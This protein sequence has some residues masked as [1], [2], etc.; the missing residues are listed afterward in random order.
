MTVACKS[1]CAD[2]ATADLHSATPI[3]LHTKSWNYLAASPMEYLKR[4]K[5]WSE[6]KYKLEINGLPQKLLISG[7]SHVRAF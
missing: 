3:R 1:I 6:I 5:I 4:P 2:I 7:V